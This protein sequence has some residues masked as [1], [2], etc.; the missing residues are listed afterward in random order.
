MLFRSEAGSYNGLQVG[1]TKT[2][3]ANR[4]E[5]LL[6]SIGL[7]ENFAS[8]VYVVSHGSSSVNNPHYAAYDCGACSGRAGSVNSRVLCHMAN[9]PEVRSLLKER[10][11][12]IPEETRFVGALHDTSRDE[13]VYYD[14]MLMSQAHSVLHEENVKIFAEAL[15]ANALEDRKST[16][17]NSSH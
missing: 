6:K 12:L 1:F 14:E 8:L 13:I 5:A 9:D 4:V 17:L 3:M 7:V 11:L 15:K 16:R 2:E 10:G